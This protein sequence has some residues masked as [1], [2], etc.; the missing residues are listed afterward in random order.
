M[1]GFPVDEVGHSSLITLHYSGGF[2]PPKINNLL[3]T[4]ENRFSHTVIHIK[5][6]HCLS[7]SSE[8]KEPR[9]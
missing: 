7:V 2:I 6:Q 4:F 8:E 1:K 9:V 3:C 5:K